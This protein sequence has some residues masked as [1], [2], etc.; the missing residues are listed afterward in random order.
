[1]AAK[2]IFFIRAGSGLYKIA[3]KKWSCK[4]LSVHN[5]LFELGGVRAEIAEGIVIEI[6]RRI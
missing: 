4:N 3:L 5:N 2:N 6:G 1:M